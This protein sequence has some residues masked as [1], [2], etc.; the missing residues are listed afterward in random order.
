MAGIIKVDLP[1]NQLEVWQV[2]SVDQVRHPWY[3]EEGLGG[4]S[5][6]DEDPPKKFFSSE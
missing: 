1:G 2:S 6:M 4:C 3:V 5:R